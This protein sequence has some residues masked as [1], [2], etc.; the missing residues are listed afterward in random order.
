MKNITTNVL[1]QM[2]QKGEK[3]ACLTAYDASFASAQEQAGVEVILVGD[4]L[5]MVIK[6]QRSTLSVSMAGADNPGTNDFAGADVLAEEYQS[7]HANLN[8]L[9][10]PKLSLGG[11]LLYA[12]KELEDGRDGDMTRF[13]FA[14]KYAF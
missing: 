11:E 10:A 14:V 4:S 1:N 5:G 13:Q 8:W 6:G 2:K 7:I 9:P 12:T 3:F